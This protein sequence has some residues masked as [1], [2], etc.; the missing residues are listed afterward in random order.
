M[1]RCSQVEG[2]A[3]KKWRHHNLAVRY[4]IS[5]SQMTMDILLL[6]F[7]YIFFFPLSLPGLL[8]DL[9]IYRYPRKNYVRFV[10]TSNC[11][12]EGSCLI[13][14]ICVCSHIVVSNTYCVVVGLFFLCTLCFQF[15]WIVHFD[16]SF[17]VLL[18]FICIHTSKVELMDYVLP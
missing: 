17:G 9:I 4:E 11:F 7:T 8:T 1:L 15:L 13:Y 6:R 3:T 14:V 16:C 5:I 10:F 12:Q 18:R 2:I